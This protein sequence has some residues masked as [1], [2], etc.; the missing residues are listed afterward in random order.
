[1]KALYPPPEIANV[2]TVP[3]FCQIV[4]IFKYNLA[5]LVK[6]LCTPFLPSKVQLRP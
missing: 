5:D 1:M 3:R 6:T 2:D 4:I